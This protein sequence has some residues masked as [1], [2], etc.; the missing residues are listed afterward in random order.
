M[1]Q[2]STSTIRPFPLTHPITG[3]SIPPSAVATITLFDAHANCVRNMRVRPGLILHF[4]NLV[5]RP[6]LHQGRPMASLHGGPVGFV[7]GPLTS[8][9]AGGM[10]FKVKALLE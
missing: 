2:E 3:Q 8:E 5:V 9:A 7:K 4:E 10:E 1:V 6:S